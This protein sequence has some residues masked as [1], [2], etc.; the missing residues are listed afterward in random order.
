MWLYYLCF[1]HLESTGKKSLLSKGTESRRGRDARRVTMQ[2]TGMP[3]LS[4]AS[5]VPRQ[6]PAGWLWEEAS[7][8]LLHGQFLSTQWLHFLLR[9]LPSPH[10]H[11]DTSSPV[12][13]TGSF[14][15]GWGGDSDPFPFVLEEM[16]HFPLTSLTTMS[17]QFPQGSK[18]GRKRLNSELL[19]LLV[20]WIRM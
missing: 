18:N 8:R 14:F 2:V 20:A 7:V 12:L 9:L 13:R 11:L 4:R 10:L 17:L 15:L 3:H 16:T 6:T 1:L 19:G 5:G